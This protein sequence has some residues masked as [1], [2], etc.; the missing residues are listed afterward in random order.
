[1]LRFISVAIVLWL[2]G[3]TVLNELHQRH[4]GDEGSPYFRVPIDSKLVLNQAL[5]IP[6]KK[7]R[8]YFQYGKPLAFWEVNEYRPWCVLRMRAKKDVPQRIVPGEFLVNDVSREHLY[9]IARLPVQ[10]AQ[11]RSDGTDFTYEVVATCP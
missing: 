1:M 5:T 7:R 6:A 9:E 3:C 10:V 8:V 11:F 4:Q 2:S